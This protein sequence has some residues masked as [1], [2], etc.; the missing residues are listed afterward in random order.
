MV[1]IVISSITPDTSEQPCTPTVVAASQKEAGIPLPEFRAECGSAQLRQPLSPLE[2]FCC[3]CFKR[4]LHILGRLWSSYQTE[5][6]GRHEQNIIVD[7]KDEGHVD[8]LRAIQELWFSGTQRNLR[9]GGFCSFPDNGTKDF[10]QL[11][12]FVVAKAFNFNVLPP[13]NIEEKI[14]PQAGT[15]KAGSPPQQFLIK[16]GLQQAGDNQSWPVSFKSCNMKVPN[17]FLSAA[18]PH[19]GIILMLKFHSFP[20]LWCSLPLDL[21]TELQTGKWDFTTA[22]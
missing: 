15:L 17:L 7:F 21:Y 19:Q 5:A 18:K 20:V 8:L 9:R 11:P 3:S 14:L 22:W 16:F 6:A 10:N 2:A 4:K 12:T 1:L 13:S